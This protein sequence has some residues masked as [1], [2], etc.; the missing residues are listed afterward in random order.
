MQKSRSD[1]PR[2]VDP[3][4]VVAALARVLDSRHFRRAIRSRG[5]LAYVVTETLAGRGERLTERTVARGALGRGGDFDG[6]DDASVRVQAS[7]VRKALEEYY[8]DEG[9]RD[10]IRVML[11]RGT[12]MPA[13][14]RHENRP[15]AVARVPGVA[16]MSLTSSGDEPAGLFARSLS[17]TLVQHLARQPD[18]R[19]VGPTVAALADT[20]QAASPG[21]V[22]SVFSGHVTVRDGRLMLAARLQDARSGEVLWT[23][24]ERVDIADLAGFETEERWSREIASKLGDAT[25]LVVRQEMRWD[26]PH[27]TEPELAARLAFYSYVDRGTVSSITE[28]VTLLD[29]PLAS[30]RRTPA[31]LAM[32][33]ALANASYIYGIGDKDAELD[34]AE[35]LAREALAIDGSHVHAHLVLGSAARD[36][37]QWQVAIEHADTAARLA[38]FHPS[39][40]VGAGIT[41]SGA[42][43]WQRGPALIREAHRLHPG[44]SGHTHAWLAMAHLVEEDYARALSEA[45]LLPAEDGY[46]WGPLYR[47]M[48]LS[49]LGYAEQAGMEFDRVRVLRPDVVADPGSYLNSRMR[50]TREQ[51]AR[52]VELL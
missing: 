15:G 35:A 17:E 24:D 26:R 48:A 5:F 10:S 31:L 49:G 3:G 9:R 2:D 14:E 36:R 38:P 12:Y 46:L 21:G 45:S 27:G 29:S 34:R 1:A 8:A 28:A 20:L 51:V 7:R 32:R 47:G 39:Y 50:L 11:P 19:V 23:T 42:G 33:A 44:L 4:E 13:F 41:L 6:R 52:L 16:V 22:S 18:I 25:G 37:G 30:G 43:E 40:L